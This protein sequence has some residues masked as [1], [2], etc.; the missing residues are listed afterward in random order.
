MGRRRSVAAARATAVDV[1]GE[2]GF[3]P[4]LTDDGTV[5]LRNCPFHALSQTH[6]DLICG[7]N[8]CL[9]SAALDQLGTEGLEARLEPAPD[10]CCVRIHQT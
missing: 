5:V 6:T 4:E 9:L 7:M 10:L 3:E 8:E 1:L 2:N